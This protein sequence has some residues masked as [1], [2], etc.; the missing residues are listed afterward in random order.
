MSTNKSGRI[1]YKT[2]QLLGCDIK[3]V[4]KLSAEQITYIN[5]F[6]RRS[7]F[8]EACPGSG[9]T[10][11]IGL[12]AAIE[13]KKW[14]KIQGGLAVVTFTNSA[15][16]ELSLRVAKYANATANLYPH[17]IGTFD[18]WVHNFIFQPYCHYLTKY[19]GKD[20]DKSIRII[21]D[22]SDAGFL[23]A[24]TATFNRNNRPIQVRAT[25]YHFNAEK[26]QVFG[27]TAAA[28][29]VINHGL[30]ENEFD[31]LLRN[32][33]AFF[34]Q[35]FATY[36]DAE[37]LTIA[38][39]NKYNFV[40]KILAKRFPQIIIDECQ[41]LSNNQIHILD[42]LKNLGS[43]IHLVGDLHQSIYEF[44]EVNPNDILNYI[45]AKA[46]EILKLTKNFRSC[47]AIVNLTSNIIGLNR[48]IVSNV[49]ANCAFPCVLWEYNSTTFEGLP[50][51]FENLLLANNIALNKSAILAR[52]KSIIQ[53]LRTQSDKFKFSKS[54]LL[55][56]AI[57][58][59]HKP[60]RNT[61]DIRNALFY[62]GR[63]LCLLAYNGRGDSQKYYCPDGISPI[64]WRLILKVI[65][66]QSNSVFPFEDN[67]NPIV[68]RDWMPKLKLY[69]ESIWSNLIGCN[70]DYQAI[71]LRVRVPDGAA[72]LEVNNVTKNHGVRNLLRTTTI[73]SVKGETLDAVLLV[74]SSDR[75]S[76][77]GH[78]S[79][80]LREG[81][82]DEEHIRFAYV[83]TSR[84][85]HLLVIATPTINV[86]E[87][88]KLTNLGF[89][90][91]P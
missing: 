36:S 70:N 62:L 26:T 17:F 71:R 32:K 38:L 30:Q 54:E 83:A 12:K 10:E 42:C 51:R 80:W 76:P 8:L 88:T 49:A 63:C 84:P 41:D 7:T 86:T 57:D 60:N 50:Q 55:A 52:G 82:Y 9:K 66:N 2:S 48:N 89:V 47:Q 23:A 31:A 64:Q 65:L 67:G 29:A 11:I 46:F 28:K 90:F 69:L 68:W 19:V 58:C 44:R 91:S 61:E 21:E 85:K 3:H 22:D 25:E 6:F 75:R 56:L 18:S 72:T 39:L 79:H 14:G 59:W 45:R 73:H 4:K 53:P 74:S 27:H 16:N 13:I 77:G 5:H 87:R 78:Y 35:G 37:I 24:Y 20:G 15:A 1:A 34:A 81:A 40:Q 33:R 43:T